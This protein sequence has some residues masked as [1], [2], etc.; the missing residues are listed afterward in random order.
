MALTDDI[1]SKVVCKRSNANQLRIRVRCAVPRAARQPINVH[2]T[3]RTRDPC[4]AHSTLV[5]TPRS[6]DIRLISAE[7]S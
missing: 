3:G 1:L 7:T 4:T 5:D 2:N 6:S